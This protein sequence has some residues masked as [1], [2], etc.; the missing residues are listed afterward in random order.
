MLIQVSRK[1]RVQ[2]SD[3][4][5]SGIAWICA[6]QLKHYP[7]FCRNGTTIAVSINTLVIASLFS[8]GLALSDVTNSI[9]YL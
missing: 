4:V 1:V 5:W 9:T 7:A 6:K 3:I 8:F 2:N